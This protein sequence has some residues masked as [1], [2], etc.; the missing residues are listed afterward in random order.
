[1]RSQ[2]QSRWTLN[3]APFAPRRLVVEHQR[4]VVDVSEQPQPDEAP[5]VHHQQPSNQ[6]TH[7]KRQ[8]RQIT[9]SI[10]R[11]GFTNPILIDED[12]HRDFR[13]P[14][15]LTYGALTSTAASRPVTE[16]KHVI[17]NKMQAARRT[18]HVSVQRAAPFCDPYCIPRLPYRHC[19]GHG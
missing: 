10:T 9:D 7:S 6:H 15:S 11:F 16:A 18:A 19:N 5:E 8:V 12:D 1:M 14:E 2:A 4:H 17:T 3:A 13:H